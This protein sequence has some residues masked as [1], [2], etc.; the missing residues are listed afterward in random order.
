VR[1]GPRGR[2][3]LSGCIGVFSKEGV[4]RIVIDRRRSIIAHHSNEPLKGDIQVK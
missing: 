4:I 2:R 1:N 3:T